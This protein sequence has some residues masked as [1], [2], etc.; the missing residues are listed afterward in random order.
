[1]RKKQKQK[2]YPS[3]GPTRHDESDGPKARHNPCNANRVMS[4]PR[5]KLDKLTYGTTQSSRVTIPGQWAMS[6]LSPT[7]AR[8]FQPRRPS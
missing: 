2:T 8:A 5:L 3:F 4:R 1:M 7:G 6:G